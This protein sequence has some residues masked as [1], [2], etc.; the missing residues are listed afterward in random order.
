MPVLRS[1][2]IFAIASCAIG[3]SWTT[4]AHAWEDTFSSP[5][6]ARSAAAKS[7]G[8]YGCVREDEL[9]AL[10]SELA[11]VRAEGSPL[12][13]Q[14]EL[15]ERLRERG[16]PYVWP[17]AFAATGEEAALAK[18]GTAWL[19]SHSFE[20]EARCGIV[21]QGN[22]DGSTDLVI[23]VVDVLADL[24]PLPLK[25]HAG[26]WHTLE[27]RF[28]GPVTEPVVHIVGP[29][30][31]PRTVPTSRYGDRVR[32]SFAADRPGRFT[33]QLLADVGASARPIL[34]TVLFADTEPF[35]PKAPNAPTDASLVDLVARFRSD[36]GLPLF[37]RDTSLDRVAERHAQA[38][39]REKRV[40]HDLGSGDPRERIANS[41]ISARSV[42]ENAAH[43]QTLALAHE[44]F[45]AS[46]SHR[47]NLLRNDFSRL[48]L[49]VAK[50]EDGSVWVVELFTA[51][52]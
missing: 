32:A 14:L 9:D 36:E 16:L 29:D 44:S 5:R 34:E 47:A 15:A 26:K 46:P 24:Q 13:S 3:V 50:D 45:L 39:L 19:K 51:G 27:A 2:R 38:M 11:K 28:H 12:G 48:G 22:A 35:H 7:K 41:G 43:A 40:A 37:T 6:S 4:L 17:K 49:G 1:A 33:V 52:K 10:A 8:S 42:G 20:G 30:G 18:R 21:Q 31:L 23:V 25:T